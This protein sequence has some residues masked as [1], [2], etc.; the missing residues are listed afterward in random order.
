MTFPGQECK[1]QIP[2]PF[3]GLVNP[4]LQCIACSYTQT[5]KTVNTENIPGMCVLTNHMQ[6]LVTAENECV[7]SHGIEL[8]LE[9]LIFTSLSYRNWKCYSFLSESPTHYFCRIKFFE[10]PTQRSAF[11]TFQIKPT[12][13]AVISS[14]SKNC[15]VL[16]PNSPVDS[17][18]DLFRP[19]HPCLWAGLA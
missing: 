7:L 15:N 5:K 12:Q 13:A 2:W 11:P 9:M 14:W 18:L 19:N 17:W 3:H 10:K 1:L 16:S 6:D 4:V 8:V